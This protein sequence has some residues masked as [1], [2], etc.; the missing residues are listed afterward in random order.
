MIQTIDKQVTHDFSFHLIEAIKYNNWY[1]NEKVYDYFLQDT[2]YLPLD[3]DNEPYK[4]DVEGIIPVGS[5]VFVLEYLKRYHNISNIKPLNIP[6]NLRNKH[7]AK[8]E[9]VAVNNY[10]EPLQKKWFVKS[11]D[12]IKGFTDILN[13]GSSLPKGNFILSELINIQSEWRAFVYNDKLVGLQNYSGDFTMFPDIKFIEEAIIANNHWNDEM[14]SA[15]TLDVGI[16]DKDGTFIIE[17]HDF[18]SCS[19][20]GM[21]DYRI[22]PKMFIA[23]WNKLILNRGGETNVNKN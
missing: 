14:N 4:E 1:Q 5:V 23:T 7:F 12:K 19:L 21:S 22:L 10:E 17:L 16:N 11:N 3:S 15:Y 6:I 9:I 13:I 2:Y 8:R 18:F 20:Y